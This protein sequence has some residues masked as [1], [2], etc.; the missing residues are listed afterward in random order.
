MMAL[1]IALIVTMCVLMARTAQPTPLENALMT[2]V[3]TAAS[4]V[5]SYLV[6]KVFAERGFNEAMRDHG[7]Q[8]ARG[9]MELKTQIGN[10]SE[11]VSSKRTG[12]SIGF[13]PAQVDPTLEHVELTLE[14][15]RGL[16]DNAVGGIAGVIGDAYGQYEDFIDEVGR[17]RSEAQL[18]TFE[19]E[20]EIE[21]AGSP[22]DVAKLQTKISEIAEQTERKISALAKTAS[23]PIPP[24]AAKR[25]FSTS[26]PSCSTI[27]SFEMV[28]RAGETKPLTCKNCGAH[29]NAHLSAAKEIF[30]RAISGPQPAFKFHPPMTVGFA[31]WQEPSDVRGEARTLLQK[32]QAYVEPAYLS[33]LIELVIRFDG[34][35]RAERRDCTPWEIQ[36]QLLANTTKKAPN[37]GVRN[38]FKLIFL[39]DGFDLDT[40]T[41]KTFKSSYSRPLTMA[42]LQA[43]LVRGVV[44]RLMR[45]R[46]VSLNNSLD[47]AVLLFGATGAGQEPLVA[48]IIREELSGGS[49]S[50]A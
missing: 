16:A 15:F 41:P 24:T 25:A 31:P 50:G 28:D 4:C 42:G 20:R 37:V 39:G 38:F 5:I 23:L 9:I 10:L 12:L 29:F 45:L 36:A 13:H 22:T 30:T 44:R 2:L 11:W 18:K 43:A 21:S 19:I 46:P 26:C 48:D 33:E 35:T 8:I 6:A 40:V 47:L 7:V 27:A 17:V 1:C 49:P 14:A 3:L 34:E 32:T